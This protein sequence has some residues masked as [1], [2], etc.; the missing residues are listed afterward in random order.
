MTVPSAQGTH[1]VNWDLRHSIPGQTERWER[2][3][4]PDLARPIGS[5]GPWVSP[6]NYT[7]TVE[8]RGTSASTM[9][10]VRGDPDMPIT[11]AMYQSREQ[12]MLDALSL[13]GEIQ[14]FMSANGMGGGGRG[15]GGGG[16]GGRGAQGPPNT[17]QAKLQAAARAVQQAYG[18]LNGSAVRPGSLYPP[19]QSHRDQIIL[20]R[21]LFA[22]ARQELSR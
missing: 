19:T 14:A 8:A 3:D 9:V 15:R 1:R 16:F 5:R 20:A 4:D 10:E 7:V 17:P 6:G 2:W 13:T 21:R 12:F 11:T 22:E 18:D